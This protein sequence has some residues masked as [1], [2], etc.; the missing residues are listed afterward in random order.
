MYFHLGNA[1]RDLAHLDDAEASYRRALEIEPA[2]ITAW[3][4][5]G[6]VLKDLKRIDEAM[7]CYRRALELKPDYALAHNNWAA[8]SFVDTALSF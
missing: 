5:L 2:F 3:N 7:V 8:A 1:L 4:N 6:T